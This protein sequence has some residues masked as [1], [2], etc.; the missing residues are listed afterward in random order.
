MQKY[1]LKKTLTLGYILDIFLKL[2]KFQPQYSFKYN[3]YS[4]KSV[5]T[6]K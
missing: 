3:I 5:I 4:L 6:S 2:M 1:V